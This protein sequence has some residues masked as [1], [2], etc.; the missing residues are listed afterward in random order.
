MADAQRKI[1]NLNGLWDIEES[2]SG[3]TIPLRFNHKVEVPGLVN[4]AKP[5]FMD[6]DKFYGKEYYS[7][8]WA[9]SGLVKL[10]IKADT[11]KIGYSFQKRNY[12][13][14]HKIIESIQGHE[15][16]ILKINK[17]QFGTVVW[18]NGKKAG[19][20]SD[21]F[22]SQYYDITS[23]INKTGKNRI[24]IRIG[25]HPG[26]L[27]PSIPAG[28]DYENKIGLPEFMTMFH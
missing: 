23:L 28:N 8:Y 24:T 20:S 19:Q 26:V 10:N 3:E 5:S 14:Y 17:A 9:G 25:A 27:S 15:L 6:V 4:M 2:T 21:C 16:V 1:I 18:I 12:F 7:N 22:A 11:M 13:W